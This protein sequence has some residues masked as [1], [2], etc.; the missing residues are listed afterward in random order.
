[1]GPV[2]SPWWQK[3][4]T[5]EL[6]SGRD[7]KGEGGRRRWGRK[8]PARSKEGENWTCSS[9]F[10]GWRRGPQGK[11][12]GWPLEAEND[13]YLPGSKETGTSVLQKHWTKFCQHPDELEHGFISRTSQKKCSLV[14]TLLSALCDSKQRAIGAVLCWDFWDNTHVLL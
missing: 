5:E 4:T 13:P 1:M 7:V 3:R 14:N 10:W 11:G 9:Q 2:F 8:G 12:C 6:V